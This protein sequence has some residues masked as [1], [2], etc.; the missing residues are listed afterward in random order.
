MPLCRVPLTYDPSSA[1]SSSASKHS[2][3]PTEQRFMQTV[4]AWPL[5]KKAQRRSWGNQSLIAGA[6][7]LDHHL[8]FQIPVMLYG[9]LFAE[10]HSLKEILERCYDN[11]VLWVLENVRETAKK[12]SKSENNEG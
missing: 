4:P 9:F 11:L 7:N 1:D 3:F 6:K 5:S 10:T 2:C 8:Q 12:L